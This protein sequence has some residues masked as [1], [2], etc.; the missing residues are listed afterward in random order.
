MTKGADTFGDLYEAFDEGMKDFKSGDYDGGFLK[1]D[2]FVS[3]ETLSNLKQIAA[4]LINNYMAEGL[5]K[6]DAID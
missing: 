1:P 2:D 4:D 3:P 5:S 6:T